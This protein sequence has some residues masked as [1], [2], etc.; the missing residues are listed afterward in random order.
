MKSFLRYNMH[1]ISCLLKPELFPFPESTAC[2]FCPSA[3]TLF[4]LSEKTPLFEFSF[5]FGGGEKLDEME[6]LQVFVNV[7]SA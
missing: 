6:I 2:R 3:A 1:S 5:D 4:L 7:K